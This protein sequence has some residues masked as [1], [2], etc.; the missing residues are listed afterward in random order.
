G[1]CFGNKCGSW[2]TFD[3]M[4]RERLEFRIVLRVVAAMRNKKDTA[5]SRGIRELSNVRQQSFSARH[6]KISTGQHE[7]RL[8]INFPENNVARNHALRRIRFLGQAY[9]KVCQRWDGRQAFDFFG[10]KPG[11]RRLFGGRDPDNV[12]SQRPSTNSGVKLSWRIR[13]RM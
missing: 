3:A 10:V 5:L 9:N 1:Q 8:R 7:V 4:R 6:V 11:R 12:S 2:G 13:N